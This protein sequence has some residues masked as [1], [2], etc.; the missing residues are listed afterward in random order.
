MLG[1]R[2]GG[3][4][5]APAVGRA[6][7]WAITIV[8]NKGG[9]MRIR[10]YRCEIKRENRTTREV[11]YFSDSDRELAFFEDDG[12]AGSYSK[13]LYFNSAMMEIPCYTKE[14]KNMTCIQRAKPEFREDFQEIEGRHPGLPQSDFANI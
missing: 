1:R 10:E 6:L 4:L 11:H 12:K 2:M 7:S 9:N 5:S 3:P 8:T 13:V 14:G